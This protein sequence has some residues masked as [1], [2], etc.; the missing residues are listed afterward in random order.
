[1]F[2]SSFFLTPAGQ[3]RGQGGEGDESRWAVADGQKSAWPRARGA[4]NKFNYFLRNCFISCSSFLFLF[5][6][7][8]AVS[9]R[10]GAAQTDESDRQV[11]LGLGQGTPSCSKSPPLLSHPPL[12]P[13]LSLSSFP[14]KHFAY[15]LFRW[16]WRHRLKGGGRQGGG[17][18]RRAP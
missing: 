11:V 4:S 8:G 1:M 9:L 2:K 3:P 18:T 7:K 13:S 5:M 16:P 12:P 15:M 14:Q 17:R 10:G 6:G